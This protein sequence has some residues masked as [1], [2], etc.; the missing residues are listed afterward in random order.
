MKKTFLLAIAL[1]GITSVNALAQ[2]SVIIIR[3]G[4]KPKSGDN[5]DCKG[6]NR[7]LGLPR[8]LSSKF[9][10][11]LY[12]YVPSVSDGGQATHARMFELV[13]PFAVR[14]N[15]TIN[16]KHEVKDIKGVA[17]AVLGKLGS[18]RK[19]GTILMVWEHEN[20]QE[21]ATALGIKN[22]P[23][24]DKDDFDSIW[25]I[26][27]AGKSGAMLTIAHEGLNDVSSICP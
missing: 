9:S 7:A 18:K 17:H 19:H 14:Y 25:I 6:L 16:T 21:I 12:T 2:D 5:L 20:I 1:V 8:A 4:E 13:T 15:L 23:Q 26:T 24:W 3:H 27:K 22:T 11:P 10:I